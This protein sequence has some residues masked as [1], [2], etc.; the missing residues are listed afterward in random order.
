[1]INV[2]KNY[3]KILGLNA[4]NLDYVLKKDRTNLAIADNKIKVKKILKAAGLPVPETYA[5]IKNE[6]DFE[7]FSWDLPKSFVLKPNQSLG[8]EGVLIVYGKKKDSPTWIKAGQRLISIEDIKRHSY[9]IIEGNFSPSEKSDKAVFESRVRL[10]PVF[11]PYTFKGGIPDVRVI[12]YEKIPIMAELRLPTKASEGRSNLH[13]GGIGVGIDMKSG[14]TTTAILRNHLIETVPDTRHI[15]SGIQIPH[16]KDVLRIAALAQKHVGISLLGVDIA[17]DRD[18]GPIIFEINSRPG[19]SIQIAN[20]SP[21]RE[22]LRRVEGLRIKS[23]RRGT[24]I[25][26]ELFGGEI[27]EELEEISG[28]KIIGIFEKIEL[29]DKK[30]EKI[31][32]IAK[33]DTGAYR[34]S[35]D[36]NLAKKLGAEESKRT[37]SFISSLGKESR[38]L[39]DIEFSMV[40]QKI[41]TQASVADR[42]GLKYSMIIGRCDL[43]HFLLDPIRKLSIS[44]SIDEN[45]TPSRRHK[46]NIKKLDKHG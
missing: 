13:L 5:V 30:G 8:G 23:A 39:V 31:Q 1:M 26:R 15:L 6:S 20:Q 36:K 37:I 27:E 28:R 21:L 11:K 42:S 38:H 35:I 29:I 9:N 12:V 2:L 3:N 33:I 19:I 24:K 46:K 22:R 16:W 43:S 25:A 45:L 41:K 7:K 14:I 4:R 32:V 18:T 17:I 44:S 40:G 34:T 10:H